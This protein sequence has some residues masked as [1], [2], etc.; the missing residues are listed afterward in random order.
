M[1][2][3]ATSLSL[4][5]LILVA[6]NLLLAVSA[7]TTHTVGGNSGWT[8]PFGANNYTAWASIQTFAVGDTLVFN[9]VNGT[10]DVIQVPW[11]SFNSCSTANQIGSTFNTSPA[12]LPITTAGMHYYICR[13]PGHCDA[14]QRLAITVPA[15]STSASPPTAA[16][17]APTAPAPGG[18]SSTVP[19]GPSP[20][21]QVPGS[22]AISVPSMAFVALSSLLAS[23][24]L[25]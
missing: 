8:I 1:A 9:F 15:S 10:H 18:S 25:F 11:A 5:G 2:K 23:Q 17:T 21:G 19:S 22:G 13:F 4:A 16:S 20:G 12:R 14:G 3:E 6:A 7:A 24:F